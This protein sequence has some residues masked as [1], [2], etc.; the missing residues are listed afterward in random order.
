MSRAHGAIGR[1][2]AATLSAGASAAE[3]AAAAALGGRAPRLLQHLSSQQRPTGP[4]SRGFCAQGASVPPGGHD[5]AADS[6]PRPR[7][8]VGDLPRTRSVQQEQLAAGSDRDSVQAAGGQAAWPRRSPDAPPDPATR[9]GGRET[10]GSER[11][12]EEA[13]RMTIRHGSGKSAEVFMAG[14]EAAE[15]H[16]SNTA[17]K[18]VYQQQPSPYSED[19]G[20]GT[21]STAGVEQV[22]RQYAETAGS[23][24][25][26]ARRGGPTDDVPELGGVSGVFAPRGEMGSDYGLRTPRQP[27]E[28]GAPPEAGGGVRSGSEVLGMG[29]GGSGSGGGGSGGGGSGGG[30][31]GGGG[32]GGAAGSWPRQLVGNGVSETVKAGV[33]RLQEAYKVMFGGAPVDSD[34]APDRSGA[35]GPKPGPAKPGDAGKGATPR[36]GWNSP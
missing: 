15:A 3:P 34:R 16:H 9:R 4:S 12:A 27:F 14:P 35:G 30:G 13:A 33:G 18:M 23:S 19:V 24:N 32:G 31:S 6:P 5:P 1:L 22:A 28:H 8:A 10:M 2:L 17:V 26:M 20:T 11:E 21:T 36:E 29:G 7:P 25:E